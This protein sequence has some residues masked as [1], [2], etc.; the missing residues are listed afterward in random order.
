MCDSIVK[1]KQDSADATLQFGTAK[2]KPVGTSGRRPPSS[3]IYRCRISFFVGL[4][5]ERDEKG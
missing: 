3:L 1:V 5:L 4:L 2:V